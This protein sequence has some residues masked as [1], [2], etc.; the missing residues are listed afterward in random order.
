MRTL[1]APPRAELAPNTLHG[2]ARM[3]FK[4]IKIVATA[5]EVWATSLR[6]PYAR[7]QLSGSGGQL[8]HRR[9]RLSTGLVLW[10]AQLS[11]AG[12]HTTTV[13]SVGSFEPAAK[14][15]SNRPLPCALISSG[16]ARATR[17]KSAPRVGNNADFDPVARRICSKPEHIGCTRHITGVN[18]STTTIPRRSPAMTH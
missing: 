3:K 16:L 13:T 6:C 15:L 4:E 9:S 8:G 18:P 17:Q 5:T 7:R 11:I 12:A 14:S 2:S 1:R 10:A